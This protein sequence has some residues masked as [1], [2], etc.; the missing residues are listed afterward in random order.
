LKELAVLFASYQMPEENE[1]E[2]AQRVKTYAL[3]LEGVSQT[4][5]E[6]AVRL[7]VQGRVE[8]ARPSLLPMPAELAAQARK[9]QEKDDL[10]AQRRARERREHERLKIAQQHEPTAE[11][12]AEI[13]KRMEKLAA[14]LAAKVALNET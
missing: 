5:I 8:R 13:G 11:E 3:A 6:R 1:A 7:F 14:E 4:N 2:F 10:I 9:L 12:R